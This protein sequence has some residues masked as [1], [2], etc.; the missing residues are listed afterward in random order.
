M[1]MLRPVAIGPAQLVSSTI[2]EP[3]GGD[4]AL[5]SNVTSY[6]PG[7]TVRLVGTHHV[8]RSLQA[9]NVGH[10]PDT[11]PAWWADLGGTNRWA[12]FD[13]VTSSASQATTSMTAVFDPGLVDGLALL[14][15]VGNTATVT[16]T[17][18]PGGAT[19]YSRTLALTAP[20]LNDWYTYFFEPNRQVSV[21]VLSDLPPYLNGRITVQI[22]A[23]SGA[24]V[25]CGTCMPGRSY[26]IGQTV[27]GVTAGIRDYSKKVVDAQTGLV[28][29]EQ[30][31]YS[32]TL[33]AQ[34]RADVALAA[35]ITERL[36]ELRSVP[37]LWMADRT[38]ELTP[39]SVYGFYKDFSLQV[40]Y[41][42]MGVYSLE[43]EGMA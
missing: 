37:C 24:P 26:S 2:A 41:P 38:G 39:L 9:G 7:D 20:R 40:G 35:E 8:Y 15:C 10:T 14:N 33:R 43:I 36:E 32:K 29:L 12:M 30:G 13:T 27:Y 5:W 21:F 28:L 23:D 4:P 31:R 42:T 11:S 3:S 22:S 34:V 25:A 19:V 1:K 16:M 18:G 6:A 17:D